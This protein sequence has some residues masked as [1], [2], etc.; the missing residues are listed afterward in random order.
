MGL[1][2]REQDPEAQTPDGYGRKPEAGLKGTACTRNQADEQHTVAVAGI[3]PE[4][5]HRLTPRLAAWMIKR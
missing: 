1:F 3:S 5:A 2:G 4:T